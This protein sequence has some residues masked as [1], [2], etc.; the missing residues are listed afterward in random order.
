M[1]TPELAEKSVAVYTTMLNNL[2]KQ[3]NETS[4]DFLLDAER[5]S[6]WIDG[7]KYAN[8]TRKMYYIAIVNKIRGQTDDKTQKA[9]EVYRKKMEEYNNKQKAIYETQ[10]LNEKEKNK[11]LPWKEV[12]EVRKKL[13]TNANDLYSFQEYLIVCLYTMMPPVRL[14]YANMKVVHGLPTDT[15]GNYMAILPQNKFRFILNQYKT[16]K[17]YGQAVFDAPPSLCK[18]IKQWL[19]MFLETPE[20]LLYSHS[21]EPMSESVLSNTVRTIFQREANKATTITTLRQSFVSHQR[22]GE[23]PLRSLK[24]M[25]KQ[26]CQS[27]DMNCL[28]RRL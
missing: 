28:Y 7:S 19:G 25:A 10:E 16:A 17:T 6:G 15:S 21:G 12:L 11:F 26:M 23:L 5:V 20:W 27:V 9:L 13:E 24:S 2:K 22:K 18:V 3:L 8:N 1:A 4:E 14:D